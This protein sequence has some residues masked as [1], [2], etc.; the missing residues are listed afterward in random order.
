LKAPEW[1]ICA[2]YH[3]A[4]FDETMLARLDKDAV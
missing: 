1:S 3:I 2:N 4:I